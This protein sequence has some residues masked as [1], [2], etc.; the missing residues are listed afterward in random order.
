MVKHR[1][2]GN[3]WKHSTTSKPEGLR[4]RQDSVDPERKGEEE[5]HCIGMFLTSQ[6]NTLITMAQEKEKVSQRNKYLTG[7][8]YLCFSFIFPAG[9]EPTT[10]QWNHRTGS[11]LMESI[12]VSSGPRSRVEKGEQGTSRNRQAPLFC[13]KS[14]FREC[15]SSY[16]FS[17][18]IV[19]LIPLSAP[20]PCCFSY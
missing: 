4:G 7:Q 20:I 16:G 5:N 11:P 6:R 3:S 2:A 15:T 1:R 14:I 18:Q 17:L 12:K 19:P 8:P 10:T 13:C 9:E